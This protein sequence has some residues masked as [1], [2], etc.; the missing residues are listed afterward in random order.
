MN[1]CSSFQSWH[2]LS[3]FLIRQQV[4]VN[5]SLGPPKLPDQR[6]SD[7]ASPPPPTSASLSTPP[8]PG[9]HL[10]SLKTQPGCGPLAGGRAAWRRKPLALL[11]PWIASLF[12]QLLRWKHWPTLLLNFAWVPR[13]CEKKR[14]P[15]LKSG[16]NTRSPEEVI[17]EQVKCPT[18][19]THHSNEVVHGHGLSASHSQGYGPHK[20][21]E[22]EQV[23][24]KVLRAWEIAESVSTRTKPPSTPNLALLPPEGMISK[25]LPN[26]KNTQMKISIPQLVDMLWSPGRGSL[27]GAPKLRLL[28]C[29]REP[30][31]LPSPLKSHI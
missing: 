9:R 22:G 30:P 16:G 17:S 27:C 23:I 2:S 24:E 7:F 1:F 25:H 18:R 19:K 13:F 29:L 28:N 11:A 14:S 3:L 20:E 15:F 31:L 12:K 4:L 10:S 26:F 5:T 8:Q 6:H 21:D